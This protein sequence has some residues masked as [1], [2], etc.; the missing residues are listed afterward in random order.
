M[1]DI[2][3]GLSGQKAPTVHN[4]LI[5]PKNATVLDSRSD[6]PDLGP[7]GKLECSCQQGGGV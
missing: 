1:P 2:G 5:M 4:S 3:I 7:G 6:P